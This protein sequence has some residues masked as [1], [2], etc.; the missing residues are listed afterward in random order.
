[1]AREFDRDDFRERAESR[2]RSQVKR[3]VK[4]SAKKK[5]KRRHPLSFVVWI[6]ALA[7]GVGAGALAYS[8]VT[9]GDT[10]E[11]VG[12]GEYILE[13]GSGEMLFKDRGARAVSRG[14]D[15]SDKV[16]VET[17]LEKNADGAYII[18]CSEEA[19]YMIKYRVKD[20]KY[21]EVTL[22]R[23][24]RVTDSSVETVG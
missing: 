10:F 18:D 5:V 20:E 11:L 23:I 15:I 8:A 4:R 6:L 22:H 17:T 3:R 12:Q 2:A 14:Q 1:M 7:V 24:F 16:T 13:V 9:A 21:G 19:V